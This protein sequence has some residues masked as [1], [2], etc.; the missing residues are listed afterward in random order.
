[1]LV[2]LH[3][4]LPGIPFLAARQAPAP[5]AASP[6]RPPR[7]SGRPPA[8]WNGQMCTAVLSIEPG[9]PVLLAGVRDELADR[10]WDPPGWHWPARPGLIGGLD[11][12]AGGTWLAV[13]PRERRAACVLN[14]VGQAAPAASRRSRGTLPL[15]AADGEPLDR[16]ALRYLDP[17]RLLTAEPGG[18]LIQCWD[19]RELSERK[20]PPGLHMVVNSGLASDL[21][22]GAASAQEKG[23][24]R[25]PD[26]REHELRRIGHFRAR[27][28]AAP[29]P[30]ANSGQPVAAAWAGWFA[31]LNGDGL[32]PADQRALIVRRDLGG[33][34][35]WGTSSISLVAL[36]GD[37]VRYDFTAEPGD[38]GAWYQVL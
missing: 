21:A 35:I 10:A 38:A 30:A 6:F 28:E 1:M 29:R 5:A 34:R 18:S 31:L 32:D 19:G 22:G 3:P 2:I 16:S 25:A 20:L 33:G 24:I 9:L 26:G 12:E 4:G 23:V 11:R 8:W 14:G 37:A 7:R 27:F 13:C 17:F 36:S 15:L